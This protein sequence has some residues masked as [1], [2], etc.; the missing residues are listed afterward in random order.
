MVDMPDA[1][2][3]LF[4]R[5]NK[6]QAVFIMILKGFRFG[7]LL[8]IAI[9]PICLFILKSATENGFAAAETGVLGVTLVD[10][11]FVFAAFFGLD[12]LLGKNRKT[13]LALKIF[14]AVVFF[15]FG[16]GNILS[17]F[18]I[19]IIPSISASGNQDHMN[20]FAYAAV[21]TLANPLTIL[22]WAGV[23]T[24]KI[25]EENMKREGMAL[26]GLGAVLTT[27]IFL[28]LIAIAGAL[29][30]D[31][32]PAWVLTGLNLLVGLALVYF[33]VKLLFKKNPAVTEDI[34]LRI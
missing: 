11:A 30:K 9:G 34:Q 26:F 5:R 20:T 31:I 27:P 2:A 13:T 4:K 10:A 29:F 3:A 8:Q 24:A 33:G 14:G 28:T 17:V 21:I 7:M 23:F 1:T 15:V 32:L 22:F 25:A 6:I 19:D 16:L 12:A 18:Q